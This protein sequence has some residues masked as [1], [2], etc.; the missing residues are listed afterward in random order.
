MSLLIGGFIL[1]RY[2]HLK[3]TLP[4]FVEGVQMGLTTGT[5]HYAGYCAW[6]Q[7]WHLLFSGEP[8]PQVEA[9]S[10]Q[11]EETCEKI[12]LGRLKDWCLLVHQVTLS[13]Q[14]KS[15]VPWILKGDIYDEQEKLA[16]A[17]QL[18]DLAD[19][20]RIFFYKAWLHYVF[21]QPQAAVNF[22]REAESYALYAGGTYFVPL[23]YFYDTLAN[24][25]L[26]DLQTTDERSQILERIDHNLEQFEVW[27]CFAPMNHQHKQDLMEAEKARLEGRYWGAIEF[28][29][30]AIQGAGDNEFLHEEALAY[31]LCSQ[32]WLERG[33]EEIARMYL[34]KAQNLYSLWGAV[35]KV[36]QLEAKYG[37]KI[38][39][40]QIQSHDISKIVEA[41]RSD[42]S[43]TSTEQA[44]KSWLD[45]TSL[46]KANYTLSQTVQVTDLLVQMMKILLENAGAEKAFILYQTEGK[47]FIE[48]GAH[49]QDSAIQTELHIPLSEAT[50]LSLSVFN[51]V[52]HSGQAVVLMNAAED[53]QFGADAYFQE[54]GVKSVL[55]L[56][57]WHKGELRLVLYLENNLVEGA[58][59]ENRLELLQ[60]LSGQ[61]AI[62][63]EN[64]LMVDSLKT[65]ITERKRAEDEIRKLNEEL[66]QRVADRTA[67][68]EAA[69]IELL[70]QERLATLG[71]LTA[72][73]SHEIRNPLATIRASTF[74]ITSKTR[75]KGLGV[76]RALK[77][78]ERSVTR[79]D[80]IITELLDYTRMPHSKL[81]P[82]RFDPWL[83]QLLTE[84]MLP[85]DI[86]LSHELAS[87]VEIAL[88]PERFRRVM[89]N[90]LDNACQA[91][92]EVIE[93]DR[94]EQTLTVRTEVS[95]KRL[96]VSIA[97]TGP[98]I[99]PDVLP[100]IFEPLYSTRGFGVGLGLP[101]V[102]EIIQQHH[103]DIAITSEAGQGTRV[104]LW[105]PVLPEEGAA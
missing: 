24:A 52:V 7:V 15:E 8:L 6:W 58:F 67:Q 23:F 27:V 73:V 95:G 85:E 87:G 1:H 41:P 33:N 71:K 50:M 48:A 64:A 19:V 83:Q 2:D 68:L 3:Q 13:L 12:Q 76:E 46:L 74:S 26:A 92:E 79:C 61:M 20:F 90:L 51:Y 42:Q 9:I 82:V 43:P 56:P 16:L 17:F 105:L 35:A 80:D 4:V 78:L 99:P 93:A 96:R 101:I 28:Y 14:G 57:I 89:I 40:Y 103:G 49:I 60:L 69:Q 30:K 11:A 38:Y 77:R 62:S 21:D 98:G 65:S 25:A 34:Q 39:H 75:D 66:E 32:F 5:F 55:C 10:Q 84:L 97:D 47:W 44:A 54:Q 37:Q 22:F 45:V 53:S 72:T 88:D 100:H 36:E 94:Q 59:T 102:K 104:T 31:E 86:T 63:L 70:R 91:M 29:Q 18:N 81:E